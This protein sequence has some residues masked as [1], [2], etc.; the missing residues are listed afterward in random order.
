MIALLRKTAGILG[1]NPMLWLPYV[2][3]DLLAVGLWRLRGI[4]QRSI[5]QWFMM[6]HS[7]LGGNVVVPDTDHSALAK[8]SITYAPVGLSTIFAVACLFVAALL[9]TAGVVDAIGREHKLD[10]SELWAGI[11]PRWRRGLMFSA[12]FLCAFGFFAAVVIGPTFYALL[13]L[14]RQ[15]L[16]TSSLLISGTMAVIAGCTAWL[17][18]PMAI[19]LL[20]A[21]RTVP[22]SV[23]VRNHGAVVA[24]LAGEA[25]IALGIILQKAEAQMTFDSRWEL[26][27]LSVFNSIVANAPFA[28]LFVALALLAADPSEEVEDEKGVRKLLQILA[29]LHFRSSQEPD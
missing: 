21:A 23:T 2:V 12:A 18:M 29:P 28:F 17:V 14:H 6:R 26:T 3:A 11:V 4:A 7:V 15:E 8:A 10:V 16:Y 13:L 22:V 19:R 27:A 9:M 5:F 24:V 20:R 1:K 25:G